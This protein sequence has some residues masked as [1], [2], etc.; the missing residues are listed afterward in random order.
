MDEET[1]AEALRD[2]RDFVALC[3]EK[4]RPTDESVTISVW[5]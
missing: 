4:E 1:V 2:Y 3:E 5:I